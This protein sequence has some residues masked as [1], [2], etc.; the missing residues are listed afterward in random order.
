ML[1]AK[2]RQQE[3]KRVFMMFQVD[4]FEKAFDLF[5]NNL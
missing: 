4:F 3:S 5:T 2:Q 1:H